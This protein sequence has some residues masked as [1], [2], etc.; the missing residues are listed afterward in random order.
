M[1][2]SDFLHRVEK[3]LKECSGYNKFCTVDHICCILHFI[4]DVNPTCV[5]DTSTEVVTQPLSGKDVAY[6]VFIIRYYK[7]VQTTKRKR[8]DVLLIQDSILMD[9]LLSS[10]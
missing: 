4:T 7:C 8:A 2:G 5:S 3:L 10:M 6:F 1:G 9:Y